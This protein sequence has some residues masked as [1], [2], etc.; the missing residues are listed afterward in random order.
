MA[1]ELI[2][3]VATGDRRGSL[4]AIRN[5]LAARLPYAPP[6]EVAPMA[7]QLVDVIRE[8]DELPDGEVAS[9]VDDLAA[10]RAARRA[11]VARPAS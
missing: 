6:R 5:L 4:E 11:A 9:V 1:V 3:I 7:R 2:E 8:L 10:A